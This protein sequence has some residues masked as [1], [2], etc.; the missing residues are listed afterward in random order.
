MAGMDNLSV[1][2]TFV[3][4]QGLAEKCPGKAG[5]GRAAAGFNVYYSCEPGAGSACTFL[6]TRH[7]PCNISSY[8]NND[9]IFNTASGY[10]RPGNQGGRICIGA[11]LCT[12]NSRAVYCGQKILSS[13]SP[14]IP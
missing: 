3:K 8:H 5:M 11:M 13:F 14:R 2:I 6:I 12:W 7:I 9:C 10:D 4:G 1:V